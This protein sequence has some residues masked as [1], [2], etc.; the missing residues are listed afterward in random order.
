[1]AR[2]PCRDPNGRPGLRPN[3]NCT[4]HRLWQR[5][6]GYGSTG[7]R[8]NERPEAYPEVCGAP[9]RPASL[10]GLADASTGML[11]R[12]MRVV[13]TTSAQSAARSVVS[14]KLA[15]MSQAG[16]AQLVETLKWL[17]R[18]GGGARAR[19]SGAG[20]RVISHSCAPGIISHEAAQSGCGEACRSVAEHGPGAQLARSLRP[21]P[22]GRSRRS[23]RSC[24]RGK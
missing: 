18:P 7:L 4:S 11:R 3:G 20:S 6:H 12:G 16:L 13:P 10:L 23:T 15:L 5:C 17:S 14:A 1:M 8:R 24:L 2:A 21:R 22:S 19:A 9:L